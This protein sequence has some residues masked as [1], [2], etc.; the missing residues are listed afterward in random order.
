MASALISVALLYVKTGE[1]QTV[2]TEKKTNSATQVDPAGTKTNP[3]KK[4]ATEQPA[5]KKW[6]EP[7][8]P[9]KKVE[10]NPQ[11]V[12]PKENSKKTNPAEKVQLNPQPQPPKEEKKDPMPG[13][14]KKSELM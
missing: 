12:P 9:G 14:K 5:N 3:G 1:A 7:A 10:L 2:Q 8:N 11:P 4:N 6:T 13:T